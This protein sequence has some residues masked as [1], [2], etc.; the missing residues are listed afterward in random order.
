MLQQADRN[1]YESKN[2][3]GLAAEELAPADPLNVVTV[4]LLAR[5]PAEHDATPRPAQNMSI[6]MEYNLR[7]PT[8]PDG[9]GP[10]YERMEDLMRELNG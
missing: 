5:P 9:E 1:F 8:N 7:P 2:A 4:A 10:G 3:A 6:G